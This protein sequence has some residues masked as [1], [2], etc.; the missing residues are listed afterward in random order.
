[1]DKEYIQIPKEDFEKICK[2]S[3]NIIIDVLGELYFLENAYN[4]ISKIKYTLRNVLNEELLDDISNAK[5]NLDYVRNYLVIRL[6]ILRKTLED[7]C[8]KAKKEK[9]DKKNG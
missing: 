1:M 6:N 4:K 5:E 2:E 8:D 3:L 9:I 7:I